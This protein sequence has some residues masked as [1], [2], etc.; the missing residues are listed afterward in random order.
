MSSP[1]ETFTLEKKTWT[2]A[3]FEI[4]G[5]HDATI[6]GLIFEKEDNSWTGDFLLDIDYIFKW[7]Q[8]YP[9]ENAFT[10]WVSPCTLI[11]KE[12]FKLEISLDTQDYS[13][14]GLEIADITLAGKTEHGNAITY[15]WIIELQQGQIKLDSTGFVQVVRQRP[16]LLDSQVLN[17]EQRGQISFSRKPY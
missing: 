17:K 13:L 3:D 11:F 4:M 2:E 15:H 1:L 7:V 9:P 8:S 16:I 12:A 5:W 6:Y 10:F 14:E